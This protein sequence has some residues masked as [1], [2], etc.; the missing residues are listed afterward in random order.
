MHQLLTK[1][2]LSYRLPAA[3][4]FFGRRS[5]TAAHG[6]FRCYQNG[7]LPTD[8][9]L[10]QNS[11]LF[12]VNNISL[13]NRPMPHIV[14]VPMWLDDV[15]Q[16]YDNLTWGQTTISFPSTVRT[17]LK[18][19]F[20]SLMPDEFVTWGHI[21]AIREARTHELR[22]M[23]D[24]KKLVFHD[25]C[26]EVA[27]TDVHGA[28]S[29]ERN[30]DAISVSCRGS[31][32]FTLPFSRVER[33]INGISIPR[34]IDS[35]V[36]RNFGL[37]EIRPHT[38]LYS[39]PSVPKIILAI[40]AGLSTVWLKK[41]FPDSK[42]IVVC[43]DKTKPLIRI[44]SN[45]DVDYN[46]IVMVEED[47]IKRS[48]HNDSLATVYDNDGSLIEFDPR[49]S[50]FSTAGYIPHISIT[51]R[52]KHEGIM[53]TTD[54]VDLRDWT[55][56]QNI[57]K[58]SLTARLMGYYA[59]LGDDP[60]S[61]YELQYFDGDITPYVLQCKCRKQ[62]IVLP[63]N[64]FDV[65]ANKIRLLSD[66]LTVD[67]ECEL[68]LEAFQEAAGADRNSEMEKRFLGVIDAL[69][70]EVASRESGFM[71][72]DRSPQSLSINYGRMP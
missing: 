59:L 24:A 21:K 9:Y 28:L 35:S 49:E 56:P 54:C 70:D 5:P 39:M 2:A 64:F 17:L 12:S 44:P 60:C 42:L 19:H 8:I 45:E 1:Q 37:G 13:E 51:D 7:A 14:K 29:L 66:P 36:A 47:D 10:A 40:G 23:H 32:L 52:V 50:T 43:Y 22:C 4:V 46:S 16:V 41:N 57:P 34:P 72:S 48:C 3:A 69:Q 6:L 71:L 27:S 20:P 55:A 58:G 68:Y 31:T 25:L 63:E 26:G 53:I 11:L 62:G 30:V 15:S 18:Q 67:G 33:I 38:E 61:F 65:L